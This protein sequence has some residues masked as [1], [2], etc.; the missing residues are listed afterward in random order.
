MV[1][2]RSTDKLDLTPF[3]KT[4]EVSPALK[5]T[6]IVTRL[7]G[8]GLEAH[9]P[10]PVQGQIVHVDRANSKPLMC[11]VIG[12]DKR[13]IILMPFGELEG[14]RPGSMSLVMGALVLVIVPV[15]PVVPVVVVVG[16]RVSGVDDV[17]ST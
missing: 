6:G 12:F 7:V 16:D 9:L 2:D 15:V 13:R 5:V 11:E 1:V 8:I 4:L 17:G 3:H 10:N 14:V